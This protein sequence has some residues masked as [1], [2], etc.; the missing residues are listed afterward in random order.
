[1]TKWF[2]SNIVSFILI[3]WLI[4]GMF[5]SREMVILV[6][7]LVTKKVAWFCKKY[8]FLAILINFIE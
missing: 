8:K 2:H 4:L 6:K 5:P 1:M 7:Y 3:G